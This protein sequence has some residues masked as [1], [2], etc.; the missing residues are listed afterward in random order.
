[1]F[2]PAASARPLPVLRHA[3]WSLLALLIFIPLA[4]WGVSLEQAARL[5]SRAD[6]W[7]VALAVVLFALTTLARAWR[8]RAFFADSPILADSF[9]AIAIGQVANFMLPARLGDLARVAVLRRRAGQP[10]ARIAGTLVAE[11]IVDLAMLALAAIACAPFVPLPGWLVDPGLRG[12]TIL[13]AAAVILGVAYARR[14]WLRNI[15]LRVVARFAPSRAAEV[16]RQ[17]DLAA[18]GFDPF[19]RRVLLTTIL[20]WSF[21]I[22]LLMIA[23]NY[24]LFLSLP[25]RSPSAPATLLPAT[26]LL[27]VL[28]IGVALPSTPG[29]LGVFQVLVSLTLALFNAGSDLAFSYGMLLYLVIALSQVVLAAPF[30]WQEAAGWRAA[31]RKAGPA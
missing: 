5:L 24:V 21:I 11:K 10:A 17:I 27:V 3:V 31:R 23:T 29:R 26:L 1:M 16:G 20:P 22:L 30:L 25:W 12:A 15:A 14:G 28:Q 13:V 9:A 6:A 7:P 18:G 4:L 2:T 19:A 8:W